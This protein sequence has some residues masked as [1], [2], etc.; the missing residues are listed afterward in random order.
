MES[1]NTLSATDGFV[2]VVVEV[3][4]VLDGL[5]AFLARQSRS[6][7]CAVNYAF[8]QSRPNSGDLPK[9][10]ITF[11]VKISQMPCISPSH[12]LST[13]YN[14]PVSHILSQP[15][16]TVKRHTLLKLSSAI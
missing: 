6:M 14:E 15:L 10:R 4:P 9:F 11:R 1:K 7:A 16:K 12:V 5:V 3:V 2:R 8:A 13:S